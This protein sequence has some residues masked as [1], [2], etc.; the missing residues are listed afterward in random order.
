MDPRLSGY[1][2]T[3]LPGSRLTWWILGVLAGLYVLQVILEQWTGVPI[4]ARLAW[5][6]P[7]SGLFRPWQ[8]VT[9]FFLNGPAPFS[10]LIEWVVLFFLLPPTLSLFGRRGVALAS[11]AAWAGAVAITLPLQFLGV[12]QAGSAPFLG[13]EAFI[14]TLLL[15]FG[16]SRPDAR[17]LLFFVIPI[18]AA[19]VA[20]GTGAV[21][22]LL[23][24][25]TRGVPSSVA[26]FGWCGALAWF[27]GRD[28]FSGRR[29]G[30]V[31]RRSS[32][33]HALPGGRDPYV[34]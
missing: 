32:R 26:F 3:R 12:I 17:I 9:A 25:Y 24:L 2:P 11:I 1:P 19:W 13:L 27:R 7:G 22:F 10:A 16:L 34:H 15:L 33:L 30:P 14:T 28:L 20:W 6:A 4:V 21:A 5:W 31:R 23:F 29:R 8:P 18:R